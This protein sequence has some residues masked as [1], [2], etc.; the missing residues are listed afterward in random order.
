MPICLNQN[1][2]N[3]SHNTPLKELGCDQFNPLQVLLQRIQIKYTSLIG[4]VMLHQLCIDQL[5]SPNSVY[6]LNLDSLCFVCSQ[7]VLFESR[8]ASHPYFLVSS[9]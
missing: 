2:Q 7:S 3:V 8:E 9:V 4:L 1:K 6:S 5:S